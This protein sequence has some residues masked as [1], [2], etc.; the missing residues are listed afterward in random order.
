MPQTQ[1][2]GPYRLLLIGRTG[3]RSKPHDAGE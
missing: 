2:Y 3:L 1:L